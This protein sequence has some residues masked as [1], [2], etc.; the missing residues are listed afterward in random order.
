MKL[1]DTYGPLIGGPDLVK[2]LGFRSNAAFR[3]AEKLGIVGIRLFEIPG[4]KGKFAYSEDV[5]AWLENLTSRV[6]EESI[7]E[8]KEEG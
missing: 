1:Y 4:R 2:V 5:E 3:R 8:K 7:D 6:S